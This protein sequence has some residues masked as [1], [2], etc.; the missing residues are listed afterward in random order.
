MNKSDPNGHSLDTSTEFDDDDSG[1]DADELADAQETDDN[2]A[3]GLADTESEINKRDEERPESSNANT[4]PTPIS[5]KPFANRKERGATAAQERRRSRR[6][7]TTKPTRATGEGSAIGNK[8]QKTGTDIK[9]DPLPGTE[10]KC[11]SRHS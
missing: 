9:Q 4:S 1:R 8:E 7:R 6:D 3:L 5:S 11:G 2:S 10:K